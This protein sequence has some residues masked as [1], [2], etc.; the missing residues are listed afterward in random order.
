MERLDFVLPDFTRHSWVSDSA[1]EIWEP[2]LNRITKAWLEIEWLSVVSGIRSCCIT[3]TSPKEL[4]TGTQEWAK[5]GLNTLPLPIQKFNYSYLSADVRALGKPFALRIVLGTPQE[6]SHFKSAF[7]AGNDLDMNRLLGYPLCC[8]EFFRETWVEQGLVDTTWPMAVATKAPPEGVRSIEVTGPPEAN[9]LWRWMGIRA[10]PHLPCRC[11]CQ[12]SV[13]FGKNL[14]EVGSQAGYDIEMDW[15]LEILS[16]PIEW[17]ALHGIAEIKTPVL[18]ISTRTDAT[19]VKYVVKRE[20][21]TFPLEAA[22]GLNFPYRTPHQPLLTDSRG[23]QRGLDNP[24]KSH[25]HPE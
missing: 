2:R 22:K 5:H 19:R 6:V 11:D 16:W 12:H 7:D 24:I 3:M 25:K 10:V 8:S 21:D 20:G 15:L 23:F 13:E 18:K 17:S 4:V 9:I 14:V 1:R